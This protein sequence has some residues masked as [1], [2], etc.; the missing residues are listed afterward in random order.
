MKEMNSY[1]ME[2][3]ER[4]P[5]ETLGLRVLGYEKRTFLYYLGDLEQHLLRSVD[6]RRRA[7][8]LDEF[9]GLSD[10]RDKSSN[11]LVAIRLS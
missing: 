11:R 3:T 5:T 6:L 9:V 1:E 4:Q 10:F 7:V 2:E 8:L